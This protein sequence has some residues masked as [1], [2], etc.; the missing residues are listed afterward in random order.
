MFASC[1]C[2]THLT[3]QLDTPPY[4]Q[5]DKEMF[6]SWSSHTHLTVLL[7]PDPSLRNHPWDSRDRRVLVSLPSCH[8]TRIGT[9]GGLVNPYSATFNLQQ[10][11][12]SNFD[13]FSKVTNK[14]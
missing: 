1:L 13:A 8:I 10:T 11:T 12:I 14:A 9:P 3:D 7:D 5:Y 2:H 6:A 4:Q